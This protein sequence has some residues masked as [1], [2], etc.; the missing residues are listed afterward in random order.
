MRD[1]GSSVFVQPRDRAA[2]VVLQDYALTSYLSGL[3]NV[4]LGRGACRAR[5]PD[6]SHRWRSMS[7]SSIRWT[8]CFS[9][10]GW[11]C[12]SLLCLS[13]DLGE[14]PAKANVLP[15]RRS[16]SN[17]TPSTAISLRTAL[18]TSGRAPCAHSSR[19]TIGCASSSTAGRRSP[20][21]RPRPRWLSLV[22]LLLHVYGC[23]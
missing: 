9:L 16:G 21:P 11:S 14:G 6:V 18:A 17:R 1:E 4:S 7:R 3:E 8:H 19:C 12:S 22:S 10:I 13:D 5:G 2:G 23:A 20:Q 15:W